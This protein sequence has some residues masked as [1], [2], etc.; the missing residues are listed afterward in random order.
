[1]R[2]S[3]QLVTLALWAASAAAAPPPP[4]REDPAW[5]R[6]YLLS[7][8]GDAFANGRYDEAA[9][10]FRSVLKQAPDDE[11]AAKYLAAIAVKKGDLDAA[12]AALAQG[13]KG[14][15]DNF[16]LQHELGA[17]LVRLNKPSE[18]V[19]HLQAAMALNA[20]S[21][22]AAI[23]CGD[24]L[25]LA[26]QLP[27]AVEAYREG[28]RR[29]PRSA[30]AQ[31]QLG[32]ALFD[33]GQPREAYGLLQTAANIFPKEASLWLVMGHSALQDKQ[34][35]S[36]LKAYETAVALA[37]SDSRFRIFLGLAHEQ[38]GD[39]AQAAAAY[40]SAIELN[41]K[42]ALPHIHL[43]NLARAQ[44]DVAKAKR[45]YLAAISLN[46]KQGWALVQLG[47]LEL[48]LEH[49]DDATK[50]LTRAAQVLTDNADTVETLGDLANR[51]GD[52]AKAEAEYRRALGRN[53]RQLGAR[54]K[55][56][57]VLRQTNRAD[58][59]LEQ[60]RIAAEQHQGS[61]WAHIALGDGYKVL[62]QLPE[63]MIAYRR[64]LALQP[65]SAW[66][67]RQ[68][69]FALFDSG[70]F[71]AA[72][73]TLALVPEPTRLEPAVQLTMGHCRMKADDHALAKVHYQRA[74][75]AEPNSPLAALALADLLRVEK[76]LLNALDFVR[77][78]TTH[79][80]TLVDAWIL[81]GDLAR[82]VFEATEP[83]D[84]AFEGEATD[85]YE[86]AL[87]LDA[88]HPR[89]KRQLG[90]F[91]YTRGHGSR[92]QALLTDAKREY[93]ADVEIPLALGHL[94]A[95]D[96]KEDVALAY[97]REAAALAPGD[98]RPPLFAGQALR[99]M[100][101][102][103]EALTLFE[104][105]AKA[106]PNSAALQLELAYTRFAQRDTKGALTSAERA[107]ALDKT[108]PEAWLF[109]GRLRQR[110][111]LTNQAVEAYEKAVTLAPG[112]ALAG[113]ALAGAL[114]DRAE[115]GDFARGLRE[116]QPAL[117]PL[118]DEALTQLT[119]G[120]LMARLSLAPGEDV[121]RGTPS[122]TKPQGQQAKEKAQALAAFKRA[123][124]LGGDD[125]PTRL[126]VGQ[127][128]V[129]LFETTPA[130]ATLEPLVKTRAPPCPKDEFE[131]QW[132]SQKGPTGE[133]RAESP[134]EAAKLERTA[135]LARGR[136]LLGELAEREQDMPRARF[137]YAC[138][139]SLAPDTAEA[140]L[141]LGLA[142]E[143]KGLVRL[144]EEHDVTAL[145]LKPDLKAAKEAVERLR[146]EAGFPV[147]PLRVAVES[148]FS[149]DALPL[150]VAANLVRVTSA[151]DAERERLLT[152]PRTVRI[153]AAMA[154]RPQDRPD[155]PRFEVQY[156]ALFGFDTYLSD[157]LQFE[158]TIAHAGTLRTSGRVPL[159]AL[160]RAEMTWRAGYRYLGGEASS[161]SERR[162][163]V[164]L[165]A[166]LTQIQW[167]VFDAQLEFDHGDYV[168]KPGIDLVERFSNAM[169]WDLRFMP[170]LKLRRAE[171]I[172][173]YRG[174]GVFLQSGRNWWSHR[175]LV[176]GVWRG[177]WWL[178]GAEVTGGIAAD[179]FPP[180]GPRSDAGTLGLAL[181]GGLGVSGYTYA[182]VRTGF[183]FAPGNGA[184]DAYR[185]GVEAAHRFF[186]RQQ[187]LA[188]TLSAS[189]E[190]RLLYNVRHVD[191]LAM[192]LVTLGR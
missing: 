177:D 73:K 112:Q 108:N 99:A 192:L 63:A 22:D 117:Q 127:G 48:E 33:L 93:P 87:S 47:F 3:L 125:E 51:R 59:A 120:H 86:R 144:A 173:S 36:A 34:P 152:V 61:A 30:W 94:A 37:P 163:N 140:H 28:V 79:G 156:D 42:D 44:N 180:G 39:L 10:L 81:R 91:L 181:K 107:V 11:L 92:A 155:F 56:G 153:G 78:A 96:K 133:K 162:H 166:R 118:R 95:K 169:V 46:G 183:T 74:R 83:K 159:K 90:F 126:S 85:A 57:D 131:L 75:E 8:G 1:M 121:P 18:A 100:N 9:T 84:A 168:P 185:V 23:N 13:V 145:L 150:E 171:A 135:L 66:A 17:L 54:I 103:K 2:A 27:A 111:G 160:K 68:L 20:R 5:K 60:Y 158:N 101:R 174:Q 38:T 26:G 35:A 29:D 21:L 137:E 134:E 82:L 16:D 167:G 24:A 184:F 98:L 65:G 139:I 70:D 190:L 129:D 89:A 12:R 104:E 55:L 132:E 77:E 113:R 52:I 53:R 32:Y 170:S 69:G 7:R 142:L 114:L 80:Q 138:A 149:S 154:Y 191:H 115:P 176:D 71:V 186:F 161:R 41:P 146:R 143:N 58:E 62:G 188:L 179:V 109:V 128:Y 49:F 72:E 119:H 110:A 124:E 88:K 19:P 67:L 182:F 130:R 123:L 31:R 122:K 50:W 189:Y 157:R 6:S 102:L 76:K 97:Y 25:K 14:H 148:G 116:L 187:Q 175:F 178:A 45:E 105:A 172:V 151:S 43:G 164:S 4:P 165:G 106:H 141:K 15:P 40:L 136:L 147:G 64:A